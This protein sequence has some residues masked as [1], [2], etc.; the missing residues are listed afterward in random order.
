MR[1]AVLLGLASMLAAASAAAD[2]VTERKE[3]L[4][5]LGD[6]TKPAVAMMKGEAPYDQARVDALLAAY[7]SAA[8]R[9]PALFP[10]GSDVGKTDALPRV[11]AEKPKFDSLFEKFGVDA[12][13]AQGK[14]ADAAGLKSSCSKK[15]RII[16]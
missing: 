15:S 6:D 16:A 13:A 7:V 14:I 9:L 3:I 5:G 4:K 12:K 11:W 10:P 1:K 8:A 2:P